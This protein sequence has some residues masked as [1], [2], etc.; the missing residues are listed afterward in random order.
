MYN[1]LISYQ[2][3]HYANLPTAAFTEILLVI[4]LFR[5]IWHLVLMGLF[6]MIAETY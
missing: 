4:G 6:I 2:Y 3:P 5:M 1:D